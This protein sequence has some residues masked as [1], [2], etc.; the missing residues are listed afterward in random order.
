MNILTV[1]RGFFAPLYRKFG[2]MMQA[3]ET[4]GAF[5]FDPRGLAAADFDC[6][7]GALLCAF[8]AADAVY[9]YG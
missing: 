1:K 7:N 4:H 9:A 6:I 5:F 2:A 8:A 3:A